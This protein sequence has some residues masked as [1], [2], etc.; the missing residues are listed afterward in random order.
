MAVWG[1]GPAAADCCKL[2]PPELHHNYGNAGTSSLKP[3]VECPSRHETI[4]H[5]AMPRQV[6]EKALYLR[7]MTVGAV[8][9]LWRPRSL[10]PDPFAAND[11]GRCSQRVGE[12]SGSRPLRNLPVRGGNIRPRRLAGLR[13]ICLMKRSPILDLVL[14]FNALLQ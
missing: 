6:F 12:G 1:L 3:P 11:D 2:S 4:S 7:F 10:P 9:P 14:R 13:I 5:P 8:P